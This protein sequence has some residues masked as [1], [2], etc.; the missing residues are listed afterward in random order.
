MGQFFSVCG[1]ICGQRVF[2]RTQQAE[3]VTKMAGLNQI[4][5]I[6]MAINQPLSSEQRVRWYRQRKALWNHR[7]QR[8]FGPSS[9]T[10]T[11]DLHIPNVARYQ[12]R[13]TRILNFP[14][15]LSV[16][17]YVV[18]GEFEAKICGR[19]FQYVLLSQRLPGMHLKVVGCRTH[20]PKPPV[21]PAAPHPDI[22]FSCSADCGHLCGQRGIWG[23]DL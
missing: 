15:L 16:G 12:L 1:Q 20:L 8:A 2:S 13:Y 4:M 6:F 14:V 11:H 5:Q 7:F 9:A 19:A 3:I 21:L 23:G 18:R 17:V 22:E 10:R